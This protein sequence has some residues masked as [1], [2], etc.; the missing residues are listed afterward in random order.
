MTVRHSSRLM[1]KNMRSRTMPALF[2]TQSMRPKLAMAASMVRP[3][4]CQSATLS[5][6]A[7][8]S[9][10]AAL[11]SSATFCA[12]ER[13]SA[14]LLTSLT[15]TRAPCAANASAKSR[16]IPPPAPVT[17]TTLPSTIFAMMCSSATGNV[18]RGYRQR[19]KYVNDV[20]YSEQRGTGSQRERRGWR[21]RV[22]HRIPCELQLTLPLLPL[23]NLNIV[24]KYERI[25]GP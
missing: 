7:M 11:I 20:Q 1:L 22:A 19:Y 2:T 18:G 10:P 24:H 9:P 6:L 25:A 5:V 12:E 3:A 13:P 16:P 23:D 15:T 14:S 8:A 21:C 4:A 17:T